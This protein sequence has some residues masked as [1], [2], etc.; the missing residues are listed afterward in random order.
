MS[1]RLG[2]RKKLG[3]DVF[4]KIQDGK[5]RE[6]ELHT[7]FWESTLRCNLACRHCG[8]D[9]RADV[10]VKDMPAK[11]F[12]RVVDA[13]T[14]HVN[15]N[16][17]MVIISGGEALMRKD[18]ESVGLELYKRGYPWGI[19]TNGMMLDAKRWNSLLKSGLHAVTVSIDGF[20]E[21]HNYIRRNEQSYARAVNA[22]R[23]IAATPGIAYDVVTCA[24]GGNFASLP[25]FKE[26]LISLGVK[27]WRLFTIFPVGRAAGDPQLQLTDRQFGE[28][29]EFIKSTRR[30]GRINVSYGCEGF[31][32][33][34]EGEVRDIFY[35]CTAGVGTA[36]IKADGSISG[37]TSIRANFDQGNIYEDDFMEVWNTRFGKFRNR[38]W[39]RKGACAECKVFKYCRGNGMHLYDDNER[40]LVCH[41]NKLHSPAN[42]I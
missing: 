2:L 37:C 8:S 21:Q 25:D 33:R 22:I 12:L 39:T 40:L 36:G 26:Y 32:G 42:D 38:E 23:L 4:S 29:M 34:Y 28:L 13:I 30:E 31:L 15:P 14:P 5:I 19:V 27:E 24:N 10:S 41:Y 11:E 1:D 35:N 16:K 9:C 18:L 17:V 20:E 7:L 3:L 6:H